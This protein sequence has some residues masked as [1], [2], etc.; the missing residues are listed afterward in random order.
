MLIEVVLAFLNE[1]GDG[2]EDF[3]PVNVNK[4]RSGWALIY[5]YEHIRNTEPLNS[6]VTYL[7][8]LLG[9]K[10]FG[11]RALSQRG[12]NKVERVPIRAA[13]R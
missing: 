10:R 8:K 9:V 6:I 12:I 7:K 4:K 2:R 13:F 1:P 3:K 11:L 5:L